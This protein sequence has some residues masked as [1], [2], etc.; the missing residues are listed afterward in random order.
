[1]GRYCWCRRRSA[2]RAEASKV[3]S[4]T[5]SSRR[6]LPRRP[7][8]VGG[9]AALHYCFRPSGL[10]AECSAADAPGMHILPR[11]AWA[12]CRRTMPASLYSTSSRRWSAAALLFMLLASCNFALYLL[13]HAQGASIVFMRVTRNARSRSYALLA[14]FAGALLLWVRS[15]AVRCLAQRRMF[16]YLSFGRPRP[17]VSS[18]T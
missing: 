11:R 17:P 9:R 2:F 14:Q 18:T 5:P 10:S 3:P 6:V 13:G 12:G 7:A 4:R 15:M 16:Q 1:M 8:S